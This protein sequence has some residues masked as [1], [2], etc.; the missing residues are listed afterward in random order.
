MTIP[1]RRRWA[2]MK[3]VVCGID[4]VHVA[5]IFPSLS[6]RPHLCFTSD[7]VTAALYSPLASRRGY[8]R[9]A[10]GRCQAPLSFIGIVSFLV[11]ARARR[12]ILHT[13][14]CSFDVF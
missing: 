13:Y 9:A 10:G 2:V 5:A 1:G 4:G 6:G 12:F 8:A 7:G 14:C 11:M 3:H